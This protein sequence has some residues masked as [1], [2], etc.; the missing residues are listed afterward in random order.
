MRSVAAKSLK[1][2]ARGSLLSLLAVCGSVLVDQAMQQAGLDIQFTAQAQAASNPACRVTK[3]GEGVVQE[4]RKLPG[5][6]E[7][8]FKK[9]GKVADMAS[10]PENK[11]GTAPKPDFPGALKELKKIEKG[12][13]KCN[14]YELAQIYNYFGWI[15]YSLEDYKNSVT[16]YNKVIEQSPSIPWGLELQTIYTLAQLEFSQER[17]V[18]S[19]RRLNR[20]MELSDTVGSQVYNLKASICYQMD[21]KEGALDHINI[22]IKMEED[23]GQIAKE[24]WYSL[25]RA[26]YLEKENYKAALPILIKLVKHYPKYSYF[27]QLASVYG[28]VGEDKKQLAV[29]DSTYIMGG[30]NKEQQLLNLAYLLMQNEYPYRAGEILDKGMKDKIVKRNERNLETLGKAWSLAQ[31]KRK[32]IP[33]MTEAASMSDNGD[34]YGMVM[35]LYLDIDEGKNAIEAGKKAIA[36]GK[37]KRA[38]EVHLNMGIAYFEQKN[39]TAAIKSLKKAKEYKSTRRFAESWLRHVER[40]Q[41]RHEQLANS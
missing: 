25:Q 18:E 24:P 37:M 15:Y 19:A 21:D 41:S 13:D 5:I 2:I 39:F 1:V 33:V 34:L 16:Y 3:T 32:A 14:P 27:Q 38:G 40:E 10:P 26:L 23:K 6:S 8:F 11:D 20:W 7:T 12:C 29:L 17:Y 28:M 31:E 22:A 30:L 9:L 35:G 36:K 4:K